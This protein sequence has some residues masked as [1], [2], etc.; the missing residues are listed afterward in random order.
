MYTH[1]N[2]VAGSSVS[3]NDTGILGFQASP[4]TSSTNR[5]VHYDLD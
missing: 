3:Q 2:A 4:K 5:V 1:G